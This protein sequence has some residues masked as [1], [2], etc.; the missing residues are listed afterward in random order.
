MAVA[1]P[2]VPPVVDDAAVPWP[3]LLGPDRG[4]VLRPVVEAVDGVLER[5]V[6]RQ[7]TYEPGRSLTVRYDAHVAWRDAS[8]TVESLVATTGRT[9]PATVRVSDGSHEIG[10]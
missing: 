4:D 5:A 3:A 1:A 2:F 6:P 8:R 10:V 7:I 9:P